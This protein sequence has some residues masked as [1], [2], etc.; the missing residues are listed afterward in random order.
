MFHVI[1]KVRT[2]Y[3]RIWGSANPRV[4]LEQV[5]ESSKVNEFWA[6]SKEGIYGPFF[7][8]ETTITG[9]VYMDMLQDFFFPYLHEDDQ[10]GRIHSTKMARPVVTLQKFPS[11]STPVPWSVDW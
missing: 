11:T 3:C 6:H 10:E 5:R 8:M 9:I 4:F 7:F 1:S 2:H